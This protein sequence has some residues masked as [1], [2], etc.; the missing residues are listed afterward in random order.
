[1]RPGNNKCINIR[2]KDTGPGLPP[3]YTL[4]AMEPFFTTKPYGMGLGLN[5]AKRIVEMHYGTF[6]LS[7]NKDKGVE[8]LITLPLYNNIST[9]KSKWC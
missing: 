4:K 2:I 7:C 9:T 8:V 1:V 3:G 5:L 6:C